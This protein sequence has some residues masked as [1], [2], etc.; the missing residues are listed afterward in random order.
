MPFDQL[1]ENVEALLG[2]EVCVELVVSL[3][4]IFKTAEYL[5]NSVHRNDFTMSMGA[6][7]WRRIPLGKRI[8]D[9]FTRRDVP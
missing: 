5:S 7:A 2:R 9:S 8:G 1:E 4:S 6:M 3:F